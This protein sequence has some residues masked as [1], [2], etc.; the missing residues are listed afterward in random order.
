MHT[1]TYTSKTTESQKKERKKDWGYEKREREMR[2]GEDQVSARQ[3]R[4]VSLVSQTGQ[5][6]GPESRKKGF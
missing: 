5:A 4:I 1:R 3:R 6:L 2:E